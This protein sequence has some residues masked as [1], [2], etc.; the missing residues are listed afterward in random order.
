MSQVNY[1]TEL[2]DLKDKNISISDTITTKT[3]KDVSYKVVE[4]TLTYEA[5]YCPVC[6]SINNNTIIK[7]GSKASD[8]KLLPIVGHPA[9]L[10]L[11]KQRF[12]CK[13]CGSTFSA[14]SP[15]VDEN[16]F[17]SN[18]IKQKIALD[19][20]RKICEKD[21]AELNNV[22]HSTV[23]RI[24]DNA[25]PEFSL[26]RNYL[27]KHLLFDEFKSTKDSDGA[28][29]FI[30]C[31]AEKHEIIDIVENR[32]LHQ[33]MN[34]FFSF[35]KKARRSVKTV[36]IDFFKPYITLIKTV[37]PNAKIIADRFHIVQLL[38][39]AMSKTRVQEMKKLSTY[40]MEYKRLKRYWKLIQKN[41]NDLDGI[42]F[43]HYTHFRE[44]VSQKT[45]VEKSVSVSDILLKTYEVYQLLLSDVKRKDYELLFK[46]IESYINDVSE[47]MQTSMKT[48][49]QN[50][51]YVQNALIFKYSNGTIEGINNF[52]K[53]LKR[54]AFGYRSFLH[55]R[56][57]ILITR[58]LVTKKEIHSSQKAA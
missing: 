40:S 7:Y 27:P 53:V 54:V 4:G 55:F 6:G 34:Y 33:L 19:L 35:S 52:I 57:R 39:R 51:D 23:S 17:I 29:S 45:I 3:V 56:N 9:I 46:H 18:S 50:N 12:M 26:N 37:F 21:I 41:A 20:T 43:R 14:K 31:D 32:Q 30:F 1:I 10:R 48:I 36:C 49:L 24:I 58:K 5:H 13:S 38:S 2:L 15:I 11:H 22:S 25:F 42:Q 47:Q 44:F 28:M 16:C 8:I